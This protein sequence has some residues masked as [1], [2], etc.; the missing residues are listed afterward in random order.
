M[1]HL[2]TRPFPRPNYIKYLFVY[3]AL[4]DK[5]TV[6]KC[7]GVRGW[8]SMDSDIELSEYLFESNTTWWVTIQKP[9]EKL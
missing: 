2:Q 7:C 4:F 3:C 8:V 9:V 1:I 6:F 5:P